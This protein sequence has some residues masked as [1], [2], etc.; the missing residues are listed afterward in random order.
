MRGVPDRSRTFR[1]VRMVRCLD[2]LGVEHGRALFLGQVPRR[3]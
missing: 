3:Q 2:I 1:M